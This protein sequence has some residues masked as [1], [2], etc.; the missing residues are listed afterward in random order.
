MALSR[1]HQRYLFTAVDEAWRLDRQ[2]QTIWGL[3]LPMQE[4]WRRVSAPGERFGT[5]SEIA[6]ALAL[7]KLESFGNGASD[8]VY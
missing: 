4:D 1:D 8:G 6:S 3:K 2:G 5:S 7:I